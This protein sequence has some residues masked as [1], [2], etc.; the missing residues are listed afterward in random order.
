[1]SLHPALRP[2]TGVPRGPE[3][4]G[5]RASDPE[6]DQLRDELRRFEALA[7][8][9]NPEHVQARRERRGGKGVRRLNGHVL[10]GAPTPHPRCSSRCGSTRKS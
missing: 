4:F 8:A 10:T 3:R 7:D 9:G 2:E 1:M 6:R 5:T